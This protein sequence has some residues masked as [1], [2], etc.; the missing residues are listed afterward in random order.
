[1]P[2]AFDIIAKNRPTFPSADA[3]NISDKTASQSPHYSKNSLL[4]FIVVIIL[5]YIL[6]DLI[7]FKKMNQ[8]DDANLVLKNEFSA[9]SNSNEQTKID[10]LKTPEENSTIVQPQLEQQEEQISANKEII[11]KKN[12]KIRILNAA[13]IKNL[14]AKTKTLLEE[15]GFIVDS[16][17]TAKTI[18]QPTIIYYNSN[19]SPQALLIKEVFKDKEIKLQEN[20]TLTDKYDILI[21]IGVKH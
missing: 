2:K 8:S 11:D 1:M 14:A 18:S 9:N 21:M 15:N 17:G 16:I 13:A 20:S 5:S 12:I 3:N 7:D 19:K 4:Y 10:N 6:F